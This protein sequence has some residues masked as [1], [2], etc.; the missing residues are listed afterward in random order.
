M[1]VEIPERL[2]PFFDDLDKLYD[3][4][5]ALFSA[6]SVTLFPPQ[7][8]NHLLPENRG[9]VE[10][11]DIKAET[12]GFGWGRA[13]LKLLTDLADYH[14]LSIE[15]VASIADVPEEDEIISQGA[16]EEYY[17]KNGFVHVGSWGVSNMVRR[18]E[19]LTP[20]LTDRV[21]RALAGEPIWG[22]PQRTPAQ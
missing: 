9:D 12:A 15:L 10:L 21:R 19:P 3:A 5:P 8:L 6:G 1:P 20:E 17:V 16:L 22:N 18:P 11:T 2:K 4:Q 13:A 7:Y 14:G